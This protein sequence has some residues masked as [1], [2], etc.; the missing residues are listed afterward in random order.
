VETE[1]G[2]VNCK[3]LQLQSQWAVSYC[4]IVKYLQLQSQWAVSYCGINQEETKE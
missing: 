1:S 3:I 4:G 2:D